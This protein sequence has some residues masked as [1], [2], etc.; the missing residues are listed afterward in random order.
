M[1]ILK[2][3]YQKEINDFQNSLILIK[4]DLFELGNLTKSSNVML[5]TTM[6]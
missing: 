4:N 3:Q 1:E 6:I 5:S 2:E